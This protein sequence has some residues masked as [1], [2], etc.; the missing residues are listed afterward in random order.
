LK[1]P[2]GARMNPGGASDT[3]APSRRATW[4]GMNQRGTPAIPA[5]CWRARAGADEPPRC[6][7][8]AATFR[9]ATQARLAGVQNGSGDLGK[10]IR[11]HPFAARCVASNAK[12]ARPTEEDAPAQSVEPTTGPWEEPQPAP[13]VW[14]AW[15]RFAGD[16]GSPVRD[17]EVPPL[18]RPSR[19]CVKF[20]PLDRRR[21]FISTRRQTGA[22]RGER[23]CPALGA[24]GR[25]RSR[26]DRV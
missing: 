11:R 9:S 5:G 2:T 15:R 17:I 25:N 19:V 3:R 21:R 4:A 14:C 22:P 10:D 8:S 24:R 12:Q 1:R 18:A 7:A 16:D 20:T 23:A 13:S 26:H 6:A